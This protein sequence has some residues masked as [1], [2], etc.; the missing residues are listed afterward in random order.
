MFIIGAGAEIRVTG[1]GRMLEKQGYK[2]YEVF[3]SPRQI[4]FSFTAISTFMVLLGSTFIVDTSILLKY[5]YF[6]LPYILAV[7]IWGSLRNHSFAL[8]S[9]EFIVINPYFPFRKLQVYPSEEIQ[10]VVI[11]A[12]INFIVSWLFQDFRSNFV[13]IHS[14]SQKMRYF[15]ASLD[16]DAFDENLTKLTLDDL[17]ASLTEQN[18]EVALKI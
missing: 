1:V 15:C 4:Y 3:Y 2:E 14:S 13:E 12:Q 8:T 10:K 6:I 11:D 18:I 5:W 7:Y 17:K 16:I 9:S